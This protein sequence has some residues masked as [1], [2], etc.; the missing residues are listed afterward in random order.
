MQIT[1]MPKRSL[2]SLPNVGCRKR[3]LI[4]TL[5]VIYCNTERSCPI[6]RLLFTWVIRTW[7]RVIFLESFLIGLVWHI[8][9][10]YIETFFYPGN[11][12]TVCRHA[13]DHPFNVL[14]NISKHSLLTHIWNTQSTP[15]LRS[16]FISL[17]NFTW[18]MWSRFIA[19]EESFRAQ[20]TKMIILTLFSHYA[21]RDFILLLFTSST[22]IAI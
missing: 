16:C 1:H 12:V 6:E 14:L 8:P 18:E 2:V 10:M 5:C 17:S 15:N 22:L 11:R 3:L 21:C 13:H 19:S 9:G 7:Q 20:V 4:I